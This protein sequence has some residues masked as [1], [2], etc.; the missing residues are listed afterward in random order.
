MIFIEINSRWYQIDMAY[1]F[2]INTLSHELDQYMIGR[3]NDQL[4]IK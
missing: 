3:N 4:Y 2:V 1:D